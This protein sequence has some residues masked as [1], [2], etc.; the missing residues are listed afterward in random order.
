[1]S[2]EIS[3]LEGH[4][5]T[6]YV[7][8]FEL[9]VPQQLKYIKA[10]DWTKA[11]KEKIDNMYKTESEFV[12]SAI[13]HAKNISDIAKNTNSDIYEKWMKILLEFY[14][15][16][17]KRVTSYCR[18]SDIFSREDVPQKEFREEVEF[19]AEMN[20]TFAELKMKV[21]KLKTKSEEA[22]VLIKGDK[23]IPLCMRET[24]EA[25]F[26]EIRTKIN[27]DKKK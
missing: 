25:K 24:F 16:F 14:S 7:Q 15:V 11:S 12:K 21:G 22:I 9:L 10:N 26:P 27:N 3:E 4:N 1:M 6:S 19:Q 5:V 23:P 2:E 8:S 20:K 13:T 17:Q 18:N